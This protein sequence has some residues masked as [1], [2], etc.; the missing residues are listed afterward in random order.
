M[1]NLFQIYAISFFFSNKYN[2]T[3]EYYNCQ[4]EKTG[5][6]ARLNNSGKFSD[7]KKN[8]IPAHG[9]LQILFLPFLKGKSRFAVSAVRRKRRDEYE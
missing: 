2:N 3:I 6:Y 8:R 9:N 1:T 5:K 4:A 7:T